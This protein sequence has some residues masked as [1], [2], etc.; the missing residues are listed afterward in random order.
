[1]PGV[2]L[3]IGEGNRKERKKE[4]YD[5]LVFWVGIRIIKIL[6]ISHTLVTGACIMKLIAAVIYGFP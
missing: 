1:V 2:C 4:G 6:T 5:F 3:S